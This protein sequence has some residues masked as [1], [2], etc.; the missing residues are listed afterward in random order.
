ML[1]LGDSGEQ[2]PRHGRARAAVWE[3]SRTLRRAGSWVK[4]LSTWES[5]P[6]RQL[7]PGRAEVPAPLPSDTRKHHLTQVTQL[8]GTVA[9]ET[10]IR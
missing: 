7:A 5:L 8:P 3:S 6:Q 9:Q 4:F 10:L 2:I 1:E